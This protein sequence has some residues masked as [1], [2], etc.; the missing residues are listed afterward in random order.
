[1]EWGVKLWLLKHWVLEERVLEIDVLLTIQFWQ[2]VP[3]HIIY[4][5]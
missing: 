5:Y 4:N 1:L 3:K 2:I